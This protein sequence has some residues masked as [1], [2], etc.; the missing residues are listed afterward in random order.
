MAVGL[1]IWAG[2]FDWTTIVYL[3]LFVSASH[4]VV[5]LIVRQ[6]VEGKRSA[7][8]ARKMAMVSQTISTPFAEWLARWPATGGSDFEKLQGALRRIPETIDQLRRLAEP[9]LRA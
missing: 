8:R 2:G 7:V 6:Y 5:E 3:F 9:R 4:Q 1:A